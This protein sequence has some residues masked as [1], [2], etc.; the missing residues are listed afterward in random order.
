[1]LLPDCGYAFPGAGQELRL[2]RAG[3]SGS[4]P[5]LAI[6]VG[7]IR[8]TS[9]LINDT[10]GSTSSS[11]SAAPRTSMPRTVQGPRDTRSS[12][13]R[14]TWALARTLRNLRGGAHRGAADDDLAALV[15]DEHADRVDDHQLVGWPGGIAPPGSH[16]T[17]RDS[18]P[19]LR[20]SHPPGGRTSRSQAQ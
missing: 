8:M 20:S 2:R 15:I 17:E 7:V 5:Q 13:T 10:G 3:A 18:L 6:H 16:G 9:R 14:A 19:S 1:M 12:T 4:T 11:S